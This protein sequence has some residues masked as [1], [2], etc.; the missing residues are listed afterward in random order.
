MSNKKVE[1]ETKT[2]TMKPSRQFIVLAT[3]AIALAITLA[4]GITR[5]RAASFA[6]LATA[7]GHVSN[8][9]EM[10][11]GLTWV[12][13]EG[14]FSVWRATYMVTIIVD[15]TRDGRYVGSINVNMN[16][17]DTVRFLMNLDGKNYDAHRCG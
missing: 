16:K 8:A 1:Y 12:K 10:D 4:T 5:S 13:D 2:M 14:K 9:S 17:N 3:A 11:C 15:Q 7:S 6:P